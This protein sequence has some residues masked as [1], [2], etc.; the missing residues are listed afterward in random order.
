MIRKMVIATSTALALSVSAA[1]MAAAQSA[2]PIEFVA[3]QQA[4]EW[5]ASNMMGVVVQ[6]TSGEELGDVN[7]LIVDETGK[8]TG[9]VIGVGGLLGIGEKNVAVPYGSIETMV[10]DNDTVV[11]LNTTKD[12]LESAPDYTNREGQPLSVTKRVK[13]EAKE[14]YNQAKEKASETYSQAKEKASEAYSDA[15]EKASE[16]YKKAKESVSGENEP[17]T[18]TQ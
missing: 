12:D 18:K 10:K 3:K 15:K 11:M 6:N 9:V 13:D 8:V 2:T 1:S 7:D 14:T 4:N 17:A 16:T 5:L